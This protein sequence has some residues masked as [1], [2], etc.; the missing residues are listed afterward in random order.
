MQI[1]NGIASNTDAAGLLVP[2]VCQ[3]ILGR[4]APAASRYTGTGLR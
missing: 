4:T 2:A 1:L 3:G